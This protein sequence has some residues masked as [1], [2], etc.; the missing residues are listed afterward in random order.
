M[1]ALKSLVALHVM[2]QNDSE[3]FAAWPSGPELRFDTGSFKNG[4][5]HTRSLTLPFYQPSAKTQAHSPRDNRLNLVIKSLQNTSFPHSL[6]VQNQITS[7]PH[8]NLTLSLNGSACS[9]GRESRPVYL[10]PVHHPQRPL[11]LP[12]QICAIL[13]KYEVRRPFLGLP[14]R[15]RSLDTLI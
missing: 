6:I 12:F 7:V 1:T 15:S 2:R 10:N 13:P 11:Q 5:S 3:P 9:L 14:N 8:L 4:P